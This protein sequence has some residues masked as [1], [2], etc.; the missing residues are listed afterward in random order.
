[1]HRLCKVYIQ[2]IQLFYSSWKA[3]FLVTVPLPPPPNISCC[4]AALLALPRSTAVSLALGCLRNLEGVRQKSY[5]ILTNNLFTGPEPR[6]SSRAR[7]WRESRVCPS[8]STVGAL[9]YFEKYMAILA[10][11]FYVSPRLSNNKF[12]YGVPSYA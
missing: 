5:L 1:M 12:G 11:W 3:S 9:L 10:N 6:A 7:P 4:L 2:C 8:K